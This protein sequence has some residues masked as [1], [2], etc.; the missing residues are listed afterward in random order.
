MEYKNICNDIFLSLVK[1]KHPPHFS[2]AQLIS[3]FLFYFFLFRGLIRK[4]KET[5]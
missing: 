4:K 1:Q 3:F 2:N 5:S